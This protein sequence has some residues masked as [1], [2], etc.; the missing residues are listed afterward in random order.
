MLNV[1]S[2]CSA[3]NSGEQ[4]GFEYQPN[5]LTKSN[6]AILYCCG[7]AFRAT[8]WIE[9]DVPNAGTDVNSNVGA[10]DCSAFVLGA[11]LSDIAITTKQDRRD[12]KRRHRGM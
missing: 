6:V 7:D 12:T 1:L 10:L 11:L 9:P 5:P 3:V 8:P 4:Y 2:I